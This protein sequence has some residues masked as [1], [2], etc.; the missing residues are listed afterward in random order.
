[1]SGGAVASGRHIGIGVGTLADL[2]PLVTMVSE[3]AALESLWFQ[4]FRQRALPSLAK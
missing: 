1:M 3:E 2:Q 4:I